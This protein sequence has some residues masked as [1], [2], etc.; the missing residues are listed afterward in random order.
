MS[1]QEVIRPAQQLSVAAHARPVHPGQSPSPSRLDRAGPMG[2]GL[3]IGPRRPAMHAGRNP[4]KP[5][6]ILPVEEKEAARFAAAHHHIH[7]RA[8]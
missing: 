5:Q 4:S 6:S 2:D 3:P 1:V 8:A 7:P